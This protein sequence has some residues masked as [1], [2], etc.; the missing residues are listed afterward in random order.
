M[1]GTAAGRERRHA[2]ARRRRQG[3]RQLCS[4]VRPSPQTCLVKVE[5]P[6]V[7]LLDPQEGLHQAQPAGAA[8]QRR[9]QQGSTIAAAMCTTSSFTPHEAHR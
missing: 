7:P 1:A 2:D 8:A 3:Q 4:A 6:P 5:R 9:L